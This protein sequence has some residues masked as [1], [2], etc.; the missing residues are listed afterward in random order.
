MMTSVVVK[1]GSKGKE[2]LGRIENV[3]TARFERAWA[4]RYRTVPS[5]GTT[6]LQL[7]DP[8]Y[9]L[10]LTLFSLPYHRLVYSHSEHLW[11]ARLR[12]ALFLQRVLDARQMS[13]TWRLTP[14][15]PGSDRSF[16]YPSTPSRNPPPYV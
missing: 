13:L 10:T 12:S 14:S 3:L 7:R 6:V 16:P 15:A 9:V 11:A 4:A 2:D 8:A 1:A 5:H